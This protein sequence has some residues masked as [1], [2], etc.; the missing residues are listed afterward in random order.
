ML[1]TIKP[2]L[3][4][5][6]KIKIGKLG[7]QRDSQNG[8]P[9]RPP[10]KLDHFVLTTTKRDKKGD[11]IVD[12]AIIEALLRDG[13]GDKDGNLRTIPIVLHSD[14]IDDVFPTTYALYSGRRLACRGDG[15]TATR[16]RFVEGRRTGECKE[17]QCPC[18][19]LRAGSGPACKPNGVL[20]CSILA[21]GRRVAGSVYRWRTTSDIS[22]NRMVGSLQQIRT[23]VGSLTGLPLLLRV[24]PVNTV[25]GE[26]YCCHVELREE[27]VSAQNR[28]IALNRRRDEVAAAALA[29]AAGRPQ[30]A[31]YAPACDAETLEEQAEVATEFYPEAIDVA[32]PSSE[33]SQARPTN[34][35]PIS[36]PI[37]TPRRS[38]IFDAPIDDDPSL[39]L[40][41]DS[42]NQRL[43][44]NW[45]AGEEGT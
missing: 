35:T 16:W 10:V 21:P 9:F 45:N 7:P 44:D 31:V 20:S 30:I 39:D 13:H 14:E 1:K 34:V 15:E 36:T 28:L 3:A 25:N 37:G 38:T 17:R 6:G 40:D 2:T 41:H 5:A 33:D 23:L 42:G 24:E 12:H 11:L 27:L 8:K 43:P 18:P 22:I 4:E 32:P 29:A 19:L 26:V